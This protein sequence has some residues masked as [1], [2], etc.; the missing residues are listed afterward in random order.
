MSGAQRI[1]P[2]IPVETLLAAYASGLFP[3]ADDRDDDEIFWV[4]PK[5]RAILPLNGFHLSRSLAKIVR[6][7]RFAVTTNG[8]FRGVM[9]ACAAPDDGRETTWINH[10]IER[11]YVA[12]HRAGH[13]H[14]VEC[15]VDGELVGGLYGVSLGRAFFG[16]SMFSVATDASKVA[17]A[18]LVARLRVGGFTL[19][20][21]QFMTGHLASLGAIEMRQAA[22]LD[23][24]YPAVSCAVSSLSSAAGAGAGVGAGAGAASAA[25]AGADG[26]WGALDRLLAAAGASSPDGTATSPGQ[27]IVQLLT[28]TS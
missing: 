19:L 4:E 28:N 13:A 8:D 14:S 1:A 12:L 10:I 7:G 21:C 9:R 22:Y 26:D 3:M 15:R 6:Q 2:V 16:E 25:G 5:M 23:R 18:H 27:L 24:L 17:I 20:D 11:S